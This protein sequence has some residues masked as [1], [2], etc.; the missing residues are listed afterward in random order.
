MN[1][2]VPELELEFVVE[3]T[4]GKV[5]RAHARRFHGVAIDG[6]QVGALG[7]WFAIRGARFDGHE[8]AA[9]AAQAGAGGMVV[10]RG[11]GAGLAGVDEVTVIEVDDPVKALGALARAHRLSLPSLKVAGVTGSNGKTTTKELLASALAAHAGE[12]A[13]L[14]TQGNFNNQLGLPLTLLRLE[15][16]HRFAVI[17]MGMS[18]R[19]EIA[20]LAELARPDVGIIVNA[21]PVHLETLGTVDEV[22][23]AKGELFAAL[24]PE[25]A[26]VYPDGDPRI[27]AEV[28]GS[29]AARRVR[30]G[31]RPGVET[32]IESSR[33]LAAGT[34][35]ALRLSDGARI[36]ARLQAVGAHNARN[37]AAA[38]GCAH[39]LGAS[40]E[41][42]ARGLGEARPER[43]RSQVV[44]IAGR[45][46][47]D[48]C[49]NASPLSTAAA[50]ETLAAL[51]GASGVLARARAVA[52]IG[53]MLELGKDGDML[54]RSMGERAAALGIDL[55]ISVG[56]RALAAGEGAVAAGMPRGMVR[57]APG[58]DEAAEL[59]ASFT[60]PGDWILIKGS[61]GMKLERVIESLRKLLDASQQSG[62]A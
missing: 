17:E 46:V 16:R 13:V 33:A 61:R 43:H 18:A 8:F 36:A 20:Y 41:A 14:K 56:E 55:V 10:A 58:T 52:L 6:R 5:Q 29:R 51:R 31:E 30:F 44:D 53:D 3:A 12:G 26:V 23:R 50:L 21:G 40:P 22:A 1:L 32:R 15:P 60:R 38:A 37:A 28:R 11:R 62:G 4:G 9:Q 54:H 7:L 49:Y 27:A 19:G 34:E 47:I 45:K 35:V 42:I 25:G 59:I 57:H 39:V 24:P 2:A 48:D